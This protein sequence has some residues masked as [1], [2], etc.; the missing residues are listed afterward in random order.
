LREDPR[1]WRLSLDLYPELDPNGAANEQSRETSEERAARRAA[2][3][4]VL[5]QML[6]VMENAY[7][8]LNLEANYAHP[9]NRGWMDVFHRWTS[10]ERFRSHWLHLRNEF[11]N[12][13]VRFCERQMRLGIVTAKTVPIS[14]EDVLARWPRLLLEFENQWPEYCCELEPHLKDAVANQTAWAIYPES[15]SPRK[16]DPTA[17]SGGLP[18]GVIFI[19]P[20]VFAETPA[21]AKSSS[22]KVYE[23]FIWLRGA[24][25][26][27]GL[28][29][30]AL[31]KIL[32]EIR[33]RITRPFRLRVRLPV[34]NLTGAGGKLQKAM[35]LTFFYQLDFLR[36]KADDDE[37]VLAREFP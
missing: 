30:P 9:M 14:S 31:R 16:D 11:A 35:W 37:L 4:H 8:S 13:F 33:E 2:E 36:L 23:L 12:D 21:A 5:A 17:E 24:Y 29:R 15:S 22:I 34:K 3:L 19:W 27:T 10:A 6:Q 28:G 26:N 20:S 32:D 25:R 1:L 7:L 18:A